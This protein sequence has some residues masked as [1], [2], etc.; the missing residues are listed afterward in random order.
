MKSDLS[1]D[2]H[3]WIIALTKEGFEKIPN[4]KKFI[5]DC[6]I[7]K[8]MTPD[9]LVEGLI[10]ESNRIGLENTIDNMINM[11]QPNENKKQRTRKNLVTKN[12]ISK[13][14]EVEIIEN[15]NIVFNDIEYKICGK[16]NFWDTQKLQE[17]HWQ[18]PTWQE[19]RDACHLFPKEIDIVWTRSEH[20]EGVYV[21]HIKKRRKSKAG[22][23]MD[24]VMEFYNTPQKLDRVT[25][26]MIACRR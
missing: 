24:Y 20:K 12:N 15:N 21:Y 19:I 6:V 7:T 2:D 14:D 4:C 17:E 16:G 1:R 3:A 22:G 26:L 9:D 8:M 11:L 13:K 25:R 23:I 18:L 5:K 10:S